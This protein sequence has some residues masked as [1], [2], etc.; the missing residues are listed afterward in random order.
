MGNNS[1]LG[2][3]KQEAAV[4]MVFLDEDTWQLNIEIPLRGKTTQLQYKYLLK[5]QDGTL[6]AEWGMIVSSPLKIQTQP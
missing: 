3:L 6:W 4:P 2:L 5:N 1:A